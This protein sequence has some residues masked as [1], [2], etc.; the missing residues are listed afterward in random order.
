MWSPSKAK[1]A[2]ASALETLAALRNRK[3][4]VASLSANSASTGLSFNRKRFSA[5]NT[6]G[7]AR[8]S[9]RI[10]NDARVHN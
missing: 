2:L 9:D 10:R 5:S 6:R 7:P 4:F 8:K 1:N 3:L